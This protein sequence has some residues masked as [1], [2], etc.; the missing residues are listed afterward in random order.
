MH[1]RLGVSIPSIHS[2]PQVHSTIN[3]EHTVLVLQQG[4][5]WQTVTL[6][7]FLV[8]VSHN[9]IINNK[10]QAPPPD[11]SWNAGPLHGHSWY[12]KALFH[13]HMIQILRVSNYFLKLYWSI[14]TG[15]YFGQLGNKPSVLRI[16]G[17]Y[18]YPR[19]MPLALWTEQFFHQGKHFFV[20]SPVGKNFTVHQ[21][22][23]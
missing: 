3:L 11:L 10:T 19:A 7:T 13:F 16:P 8:L 15:Y 9:D 5:T 6:L 17:K 20:L 4:N 2:F 21:I 14:R 12:W 22:L 23:P 1:V 18:V